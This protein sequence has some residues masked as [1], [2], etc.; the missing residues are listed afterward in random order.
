MSETTVIESFEEL[1]EYYAGI[2]SY[3]NDHADY[4]NLLTTFLQKLETL[5]SNFWA[6]DSGPDRKPWPELEPLTI[7]KKGHDTILVDTG[8]L[9]ASLTG[10]T[11]DSIREVVSEGLNQGLTFGTSVPYSIYLTEGIKLKDGRIKKWPHVGLGDK[12]I[13]AIQEDVAERT[14]EIVQEA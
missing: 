11:G 7:R 9:E 3:Y 12:E 6:S 14:L 5:S 13:D 4:Y 10:T 1:D 8:R 2:Q